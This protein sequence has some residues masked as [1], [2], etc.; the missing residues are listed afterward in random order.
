MLDRWPPSPTID[1]HAAGGSWHRQES[2]PPAVRRRSAPGPW[3]AG[4]A[5][6]RARA[7]RARPRRVRRGRAGPADRPGG[8]G[9][10]I[11][12]KWRRATAPAGQPAVRPGGVAPAA[13]DARRSTLDA[14]RSTLDARRSTLDARRSTLDARLSRWKARFRNVKP[15]LTAPPGLALMLVMGCACFMACSSATSPPSAMAGGGGSWVLVNDPAPALSGFRGRLGASSPWLPYLG[16]RA[17]S[18]P[19]ATLRARCPRSQGT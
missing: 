15:L 14:R 5:R 9:C 2:P 17:S 6:R 8:G 19:S 1:C 18:P 12:Y 13:L 10:G 11:G 4:Q 7:E 16:A 3:P